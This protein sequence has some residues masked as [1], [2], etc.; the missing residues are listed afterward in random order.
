MNVNNEGIDFKAVFGDGT[1]FHEVADVPN[2]G[3]PCLPI[4]CSSDAPVST[5]ELA[6][7]R[8]ARDMKARILAA[9]DEWAPGCDCAVDL[10]DLIRGIEP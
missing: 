8:A 1:G 6:R 3:K 5:E 7:W 4:R 10:R 2:T 9:L